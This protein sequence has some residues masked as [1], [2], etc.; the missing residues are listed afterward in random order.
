MVHTKSDSVKNE[1]EGK[2]KPCHTF[3]NSLCGVGMIVGY[4]IL[5]SYK[6]YLTPPDGFIHCSKIGQ[7][8]TDW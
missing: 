4:Y 5:E 6:N 1:K 7:T 3:D 8:K 2:F